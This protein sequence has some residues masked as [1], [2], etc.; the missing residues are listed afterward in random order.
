MKAETL[1]Q[2]A[3]GARETAYCP[4]SGFAVGAAVLCEDGSVFTGCNIENAA[5]GPTNCAERTAIFTAVAAGRREFLMIAISGG[6]SGKALEVCY[7]CGI[8]RQVMAEFADV[9]KFQ[10]VCGTDTD[11]LEIHTLEEL[12]PHSFGMPPRK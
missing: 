3:V 2:L 12:L 8:C 1:F 11:T 5:F 6:M 9:P 4:Y 10:I 7:P